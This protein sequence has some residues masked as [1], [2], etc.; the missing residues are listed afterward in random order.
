MHEQ[1]PNMTRYDYFYDEQ[2]R[3]FLLQVVRAFSGFQYQTGRR[4]DIGPQLK[5]VPCTMAKRNRQ[6]AFI[7][8]NGSENVINTCPMITVDLANFAFDESRLQNPGHIGSVQV[9]E[10]GRDAVTGKPDG[11]LG[12]SITVER[13]MPRPFMMTVQI[14]IWTSNLDQK[15]QLVEQIAQIIYPTFDIQSSDNP[16]DW[17][18]LTVVHPK[19]MTWTSISTPVGNDEQIDITTIQLEIPMWL[20]PPAKIKRQKIIDQIITNVNEGVRDD[21]GNLING[22]RMTQ[23]V[24]NPKENHIKVTTGSGGAHAQLLGPNANELSPDG[25]R[26]S[27]TDL[28]DTYGKALIPART[29]LRLSFSTEVN[30]PEIIG[31]L[32][33]GVNGWTLDWQIDLDTLPANTL[34]A[35]NAVIDPI[36]TEPGV[37]LPA[38]V[39]G[40]RYLLANDL[41]ANS[42]AWGGTGARVGAIIEYKVAG[43]VVVFD[44]LPHPHQEFVLNLASGK[45]LRWTGT[46]WGMAIDGTYAPGYWRLV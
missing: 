6:V 25:A 16:I 28:F 33:A 36:R 37:H 41:P 12:N 11:K 22:S 4:G 34:S 42:V 30:A 31:T 38:A 19:D 43:W 21:E 44:G 40:Q 17:S 23:I 45:Q 7:Q 35:V 18:A 13:L 3:R 1:L 2:I 26:Y 14:D 10:Q 32:Q 29:Q 9:Y 39:I 24:T 27:W 8:K 46:E 20:S 15:C 5:I